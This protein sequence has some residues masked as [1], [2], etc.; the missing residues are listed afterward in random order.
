MND[1]IRFKID[2]SGLAIASLQVFRF[3]PSLFG[4][5]WEKIGDCKQTVAECE[6]F[7]QSIKHLPL[8]RS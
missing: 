5:K 4:G 1:A 6:E 2:Y 8:Y 3:V 7:I